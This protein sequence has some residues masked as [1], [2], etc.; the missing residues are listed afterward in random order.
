MK[1][2][3]AVESHF[4]EY[5]GPYTAINQKIE[6]LN[7]RNIKNKLIY[8]K[9]NQFNFK[10][11]LN[12]LIKDFDIIHIYGIWRPFLARVFLIAKKLNKKIILSPI[13][14]LEPWSLKQKKLKKKLAWFIYQKKI[15]ENVDL[16]HATSDIEAENILNKN[17]KTKI[18]IIGHGLEID[19]NY[20]LKVKKNKNKKIIFFSR[21]HNKKGILELIESWN[22]IPYKKEWSLDIYGPV[23]DISYFNKIKKS[24]KYFNLGDSVKYFEP[25]FS[26]FEKEKI[27]KNADGF[28]LPSK[29]ENFGISIGESLS[30]GLPVLTTFET[31]WKI[32]NDYNAGYVF[33]FSK[34]NIEFYLEKF[35]NLSDNERY[36][37]GLKGIQLINDKFLSKNIFYKYESMYEE[38][39]NESLIG[40]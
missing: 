18:K 16:I 37:M 29:S 39:L 17:I 27:F 31:P 9:T 6:Y 8:K 26:N 7:K 20:S 25:I 22:K 32:I 1:I 14:A 34:T 4:K 13:G 19:P 36:K 5:G 10:L 35:L 2:L 23:S 40:Y 11:D 12:Y 30:F 15:L 21:I 24:I 38:L 33:N 3:I 28:I